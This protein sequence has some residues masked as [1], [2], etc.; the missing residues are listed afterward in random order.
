MNK[1]VKHVVFR[2]DTVIKI[3]LAVRDL[4]NDSEKI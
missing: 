2:D 1:S 4:T 3:E